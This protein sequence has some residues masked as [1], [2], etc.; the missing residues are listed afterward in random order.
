[1]AKTSEQLYQEI[2]ALEAFDG[3][4]RTE[5]VVLRSSAL[6]AAR[7]AVDMETLQDILGPTSTV[8]SNLLYA[9][10]EAI[11][12]SDSDPR[13]KATIFQKLG[14]AIS[15]IGMAVAGINAKLGEGWNTA[16]KEISLPLT[17]SI[18]KNIKSNLIEA[19]TT[20]VASITKRRLPPVKS[21]SITPTA[22]Y[23]R[24]MVYVRSFSVSITAT[25]SQNAV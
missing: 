11:E 22:A 15:R 18:T 6:A 4:S 17:L 14:L 1:M 9:D 25:P 10:I 12:S 21:A 20:I 24:N 7:L 19:A 5:E 16:V 13:I 3:D 2:D 8:D 23:S